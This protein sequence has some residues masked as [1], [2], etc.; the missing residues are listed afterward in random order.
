[1]DHGRALLFIF[2]SLHPSFLIE[3]NDEGWMCDCLPTNRLQDGVLDHCTHIKLESSHCSISELCLV[4][5]HYRDMLHTS[6][7]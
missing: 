3:L 4:F 1:M 6:S 7:E 2:G 5:L